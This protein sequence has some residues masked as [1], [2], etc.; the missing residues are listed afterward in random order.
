M[1]ESHITHTSQLWM[2]RATHEQ[3][4]S[5]IRMSHFR[6]IMSHTWMSHVTDMNWVMSHTSRRYERV[7]PQIA[8][9]HIT[10]VNESRHTYHFTHINVS[11]HRYHEMS[12]VTHMNW[13]MSYI[14]HSSECVVPHI[15]QSCHSIVYASCHR[16]HELSHIT[17]TAQ[18]W[19]S[20]ATHSRESFRSS[21]WFMTHIWNESCHT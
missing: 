18:F 9:S 21:E 19:M 4:I 8:G 13:V 11:C 15:C 1:R 12:H 6:H 2:S 20:R 17:H 14:S 5:L 10:L 16:Y 7:V 3:V